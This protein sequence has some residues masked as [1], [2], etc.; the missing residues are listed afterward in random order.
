MLYDCTIWEAHII[1]TTYK[2]Y[3]NW[4]F[5]LSVRFLIS[6]RLLV[7][8]EGVQI[9]MWASPMARL[10]KQVKNPPAMQETQERW[11]RYLGQK[12]LWRRKW[13]PTPV[14]LPE[15]SHGE[16][17]DRQQSKGS[18]RVG[19][20]WTTK[21]TQAQLYVDFWPWGWEGSVPQ[22]LHFSRVDCILTDTVTALRQRTEPA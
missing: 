15:K 8:F 17:P 19:H 22:H 14:F 11:V 21:H 3:V 12:I 6:S 2:I 16:K 18:Q 10:V 4:L 9:Y 1:H 20:D 13:Q 7:R 5:M